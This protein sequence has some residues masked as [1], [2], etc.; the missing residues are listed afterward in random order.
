MSAP[1]TNLETQK[2]WH[3]V[4]II[5]IVSAVVLALGLL[6]AQMVIVA[7]G[8]TPVERDADQSNGGTGDPLPDTA[9][10]EVDPPVIPGNDL[11]PQELPMP[12]PDVEIPPVAPPATESP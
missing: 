11:P 6:F 2:R 3:R 4:P 10:P 5:G 12:S 1:R 8:G 7:D 9:P